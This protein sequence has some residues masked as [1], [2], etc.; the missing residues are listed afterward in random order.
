MEQYLVLI[1]GQP[2]WWEIARPY[3]FTHELL[4]TNSVL[5]MAA[6]RQSGWV[7]LYQDA[8]ATLLQAP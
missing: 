3:G 1:E 2:G 4:P 5:L 7:A 8:V 6:F